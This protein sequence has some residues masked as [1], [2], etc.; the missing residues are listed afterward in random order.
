MLQ[1]PFNIE[2]AKSS[3]QTLSTP[4][5]ED[6]NKKLLDSKSKFKTLPLLIL[7]TSTAV[8]RLGTVSQHTTQ[9]AA[10]SKNRPLAD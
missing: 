7:P 10:M 6:D 9:C 1:F 8:Q 2:N 4:N 3:H 5:T